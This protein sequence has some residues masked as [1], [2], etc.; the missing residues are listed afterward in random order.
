M[1]NDASRVDKLLSAFTIISDVLFIIL[2]LMMMYAIY[3]TYT[4]GV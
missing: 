4:A 2:V 3:S 1:N